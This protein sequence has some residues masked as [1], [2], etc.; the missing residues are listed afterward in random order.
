MLALAC[1][2]K[3]GEHN[4][5]QNLAARLA[6]SLCAGIDGHAGAAEIGGFHFAYRPLRSTEALSR[7]WRPATL[8][9]GQLVVFHGYFDNAAEIASA[10]EVEIRGCSLLYGL[11]VERWA[12]EAEKRII[13]NYCAVIADPKD[14]T[15]RLSRSP[16]KAPPLYHYHD[17]HLTAVAS[18]PRA[19][20]SAGAPKQL[21]E[22]NYADWA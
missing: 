20:F 1:P 16:I 12:D 19:L 8:P 6:S 11:A 17:E 7:A 18:V 4:I 15:L 3:S 14:S 2:W 13:G 5:Q 21:N 10:L 9:S 22:S